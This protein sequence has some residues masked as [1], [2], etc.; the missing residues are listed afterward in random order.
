MIRA[1]EHLAAVIAEVDFYR[2]GDPY[3]VVGEFNGDGRYE[4]R[5]EEN[6]PPPIRLSILIGDCVNSLRATLDQV[7]FAHIARSDPRRAADSPESISFPIHETRF[8]K[9]RIERSDADLFGSVDAVPEPVL[10]I[11]KDHQPYKRGNDAASHPLAIV[12]RLTNIDKHRMLLLTD[13][14][15]AQG[16]FGV[17]LGDLHLDSR[18][19]IGTFKAG[20]QVASIPLTF[21]TI[22]QAGATSWDDVKVYGHAPLLV[23]LDEPGIA[24]DRPVTEVLQECVEFVNALLLKVALVSNII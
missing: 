11:I 21:E 15:L 17:T 3:G 16:S 9:K 2:E 12:N 22:S 8:N 6:Y 1:K 14:F 18:Y 24:S 20:A 10:T 19:V 23:T 4:L 7:A 5:I 13:S